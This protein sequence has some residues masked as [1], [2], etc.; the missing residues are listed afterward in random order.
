MDNNEILDQDLSQKSG[1]YTRRR[2][3]LPMWVKIFTWIF[4]ITGSAAPLSLLAGV[5]NLPFSLSLYGLDT[6]TSLS[7]AGFVLVFL[8]S[9]KGIT[10][11]G[12]WTEQDWAIKVAK[13]DAGIGILFCIANMF[14]FSSFI[15]ND[16]Q[17]IRY[18]FRLELFVFI[19]YWRFLSRIQAE[20]EAFV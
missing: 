2:E 8:F 15:I 20:W 11:Y 17:Q 14:G 6:N 10:A 16:I 4:M 5:L 9:L 19:P 18:S 12:L 7:L 1:R 3:M 13:L